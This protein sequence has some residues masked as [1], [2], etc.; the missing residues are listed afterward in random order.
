MFHCKLIWNL[1]FEL[2]NGT[3]VRLSRLFATSPDPFSSERPRQRGSPHRHDR[4]RSILRPVLAT[5]LLAHL[6]AVRFSMLTRPLYLFIPL[7]LV[8]VQSGPALPR[9][10]AGSDALPPAKT[11]SSAHVSPA[12][13]PSSP[14]VAAN[15]SATSS[16]FAGQGQPPPQVDAHAWA[17]Q[18]PAVCWTGKK[19]GRSELQ[20]Y[21]KSA[22]CNS[23]I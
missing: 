15:S 17:G 4:N 18:F 6:W 10:A 7:A 23:A 16:R 20:P 21:P 11:S 1:L 22:T 8:V 9:I 14:A 12:A 13:L 19:A 2:E 3:I 5:L